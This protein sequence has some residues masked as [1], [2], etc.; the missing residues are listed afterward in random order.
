M[1]ATSFLLATILFII[2]LSHARHRGTRLQN[3]AKDNFWESEAKANTIRKVSLDCVD[4]IKIPLNL[5]EGN[6]TADSELN[7]ML[8]DL[9]KLSEKKILNLT[10]ISNTDLKLEYGSANL[11]FLTEC[12]LNFTQ[13][14][15][16]LNK[17]GAHFY[18]KN[19]FDKA[20]LYLEFAVE[21]RTDISTTYSILKKIYISHN[22]TDKIDL[23]IDKAST[24]NSLMKNSIIKHLQNS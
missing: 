13:L 24:L 3:E 2:T 7:V 16:L 1:N 9:L 14:A 17:I 22:R 15:R 4:Y 19:E 11:P 10:G 12:D 21:C 23:L 18:N 8:S 20:L 6:D 5:L